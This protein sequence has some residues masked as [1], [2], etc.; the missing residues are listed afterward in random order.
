MTNAQVEALMDIGKLRRRDA[1]RL[2]DVSTRTLGVIIFT[3]DAVAAELS[4]WRQIVIMKEPDA[5]AIWT[6]VMSSTISFS[7]LAMDGS[8]SALPSSSV[9]SLF[10]VQK[11]VPT[12]L[13]TSK[14]SGSDQLHLWMLTWLATFLVEPLADLVNNSLATAV[15]Q[16][17]WPRLCVMSSNKSSRGSLFVS[18]DD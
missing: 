7:A 17:A 8:I 12:T 9:W 16:W 4:P 14:S 15:V 11:E 5:Q 1:R 18:K 13:G 2:L 3:D 10:F 6:S